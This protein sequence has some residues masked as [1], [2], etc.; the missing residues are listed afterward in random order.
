MNW[1]GT[2]IGN[3]GGEPNLKPAPYPYDPANRA[4]IFRSYVEYEEKLIP[5]YNGEA[6]M[7]DDRRIERVLRREAWESAIHAKKFQRMLRGLSREEAAASPG[8]ETELPGEFLSLLQ[9]EVT[10]KYTEMLQHLRYSWVLQKNSLL[11]WQ[12]MDQSLEKMKQIAHFA[13]DMG[14]Y[15]VSPRFEPGRIDVSK[16]IGMALKRALE[17]VRKSEKRHIKLTRDDELNKH[18]G[19]VI[20]LDLTI[21]QERYQAEEL[22]DML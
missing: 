13:E 9:R 18:E 7:V 16:S 8:R 21:Q 19:L 20:N 5:R 12:L 2:I 15:G 3:L 17:G 14:G 1:L 4:T 22:E 11:A 6:D 10:G